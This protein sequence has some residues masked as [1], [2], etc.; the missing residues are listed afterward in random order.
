MLQ[1]SLHGRKRSSEKAG[2]ACGL[3]ERAEK[4]AGEVL[5]RHL[6]G[7][8]LTRGS[9]GVQKRL[10]PEHVV[11]SCHL[12]RSGSWDALAGEFGGVRSWRSANLVQRLGRGKLRGNLQ[13]AP[14]WD[15]PRYSDGCRMARKNTRR[16]KSAGKGP[17]EVL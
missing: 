8:G 15:V 9:T 7:A 12:A 6:K 14:K 3:Q 16:K 1:Y 4:E 17:E 11:R 2:Y 13:V 5:A 10:N